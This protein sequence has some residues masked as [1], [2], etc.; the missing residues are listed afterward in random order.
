MHAV[1]YPKPG[2]CVPCHSIP[3]GSTLGSSLCHT[4]ANH[5]A[6]KC[7]C[8]LL[9]PG[10]QDTSGLPCPSWELLSEWSHREGKCQDLLPE[11][12]P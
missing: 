2:C 10:T 12:Q 1:C 4:A 5:R 9:F 3:H 7:G 6:I 11:L 8:W